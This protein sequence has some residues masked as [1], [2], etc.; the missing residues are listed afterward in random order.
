MPPTIVPER[1]AASGPLAARWLWYELPPLRAGETVHGRAELENAGSATW[2]PQ[3]DGQVSVSYH[4]LD[5]L[6]NPIVWG[7]IFS[8]VQQP[9]PPGGRVELWFA[10]Q[11]PRPPGRYRL[12]L[13][14]VAEGRSWFSALGNLPLELDADVAPRIERRALAV[15]LRS[16]PEHLRRL[17]QDA[18][19]AQEDPLVPGEDAEAVAHLVPGCRP[20]ADWSR[21]VLDAHAEGF[22]CVAGSIE[23]TGSLLARRKASAALRPWAPEGGRKPAFEHPLL[24][25]SLLVGLVPEW[26]EVAGLPALEAPPEPSLFDARIRLQVP[27]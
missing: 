21:R 14:V 24:C 26:S 17:T 11:A 20:A 10:V 16:G 23:P 13:D 8:P 15:D 9:V 22:A 3:G 19:D 7:G 12:S 5:P 6:G 27:A 18:L 1:P 4:W 25:P 2:Q